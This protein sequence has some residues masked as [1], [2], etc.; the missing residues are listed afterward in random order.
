MSRSKLLDS[1]PTLQEK[2]LQF[3]K[4]LG[5]AKFKASNGWLESFCKH[6]NLD[7]YLKS[8]EK[9]DV[10]VI[11][12]EDWKEKLLTLLEGYNPCDIFNMD[13]TSLSVQSRT[14]LCIRKMKN[15]IVARKQKIQL[16]ISLFPNIVGDKETP[17]VIWK[18]LNP[19]CFN[20]VKPKT[21][22]VNYHTIKK[23]WVASGIFETWLQKFDKFIDDKGRKVL[24]FLDNAISYSNVWLCNV[25]L[26]FFPATT[27][28][29][30]ESVDLAIIQAIKGKYH[31]AQFW[32]MITQMER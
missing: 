17:L 24:L 4:D 29:V 2:V 10:D 23:A 7:F 22:P 28:S 27:T 30:L 32:Y 19:R 15:A 1:V 12:V 9:A 26:K 14:K 11:V 6:N 8:G 16:T 21:L 5:N 13:E 25:K 3:A 31:Q 18:L 20:R